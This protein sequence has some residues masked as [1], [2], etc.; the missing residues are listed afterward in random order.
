MYL[1]L[2][3]FKEAKLGGL[4]VDFGFSP[5]SKRINRLIGNGASD[6]E[7]SVELSHGSDSVASDVFCG[8]DDDSGD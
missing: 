1:P 2:V 6:E 4:K 8:G 3:A 5:Y 7:G